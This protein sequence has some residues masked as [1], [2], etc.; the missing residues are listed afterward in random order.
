[1]RMESIGRLSGGVAHDLNN[2]LT[3]IIGFGDLVLGELSPEDEHRESVQEILRAAFRARDLVRQLLAFSRRQTLDFKAIDLNGMV[4]EFQ[5]LLRRT[6]RKDIEIRFIPTSRQPN[7]RADR[8]QM[9]Q[10]IMNLA[11]NAQDAMPEGGTLTI[12]TSEVELDGE[13][14]WAHAGVTS[15]QYAMLS[16]SDDGVGM[17]AETREKVFEPFFTTKE[18]GKGTGL[19]LATVYGIVKQHG[20]NIW[21][22][23]EP[24][25]GST[26]KCYFPLADMPSVEQVELR[27]TITDLGGTETIMVVED[28]VMVRKLAA[29]VLKGSGYS[30]LEAGESEA[31]LNALRDYDGPLD[32]LL[33]DVV[34]PGMNGRELYGEVRKLFPGAKVLFMSGY[35]EDIVTHRGVLDE[36]IPFIQKPFSGRDLATKVRSVLEED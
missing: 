17:D 3:P 6:I 20:G 15:G 9:E 24:G 10:V 30:V 35:T 2:L 27:N 16:F 28:E 14:A 34:M 36:G 19:G 26:F 21:A 25:G 22:Y 32:M 11:V 5:N 8:G 12:E 29:K 7:I 4:R 13:Y 31:C 18:R 1:Q 23:S 33:T